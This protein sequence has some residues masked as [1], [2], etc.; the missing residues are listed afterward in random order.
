[1]CWRNGSKSSQ[2]CPDWI[3]SVSSDVIGD[4]MIREYFAEVMHARKITKV[5]MKNDVQRLA[6][7][8]P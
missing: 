4:D 1:M 3:I 8:I 6:G 5:L 7:Q 2:F